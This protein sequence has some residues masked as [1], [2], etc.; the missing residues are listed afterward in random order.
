VEKLGP[1]ETGSIASKTNLGL[2]H[3]DQ[4][5]NLANTSDNVNLNRLN[6]RNLRHSS[7]IRH[8]FQNESSPKNATDFTNC[9]VFESPADDAFDLERS[10]SDMIVNHLTNP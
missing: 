5:P 2:R 7:L 1:G 4:L 6:G 3:V 8:G 10:C 9:T